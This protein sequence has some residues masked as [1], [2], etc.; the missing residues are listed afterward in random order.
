MIQFEIKKNDKGNGEF[1]YDLQAL[2]ASFYPE[3]QC[4]VNLREDWQ[5][6]DG[7]PLLMTVDGKVLC[8]ECMPEGYTKNQVKQICY[9][10]LEQVSGRKLPWGILT[11]IRPAKIALRMLWQGMDESQVRKQ[12]QEEYLVHEK[13]AG[14]AWKVARKE[15]ELIGG[16]DHGQNYNLYRNPVLSVHLS[17]LLLF[18]L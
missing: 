5:E 3:K 17:V 11:G 13:K 12:L 2:A 8:D 16:A 7:Y 4:V 18:F 15:N 6:R 10:A 1:S 9:R 14:L